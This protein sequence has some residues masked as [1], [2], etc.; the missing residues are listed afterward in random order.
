MLK[1]AASES[2][3]D[4]ISLFAK[5]FESAY[6]EIG[7]VSPSVMAITFAPFFLANSAASLVLLEYQ[8]NEIAISTSPSDILKIC[9]NS[10][11]V[12]FEKSIF[13]LPNI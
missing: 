4:A 7:D 13:T 12:L 1:G 5:S 11:F 2:I 10:S 3:K 8:G 9:S 6:A